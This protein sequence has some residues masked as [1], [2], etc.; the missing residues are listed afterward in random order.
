MLI[1]DHALGATSGVIL[2]SSCAIALVGGVPSC[3]LLG[4]SEGAARLLPDHIHHTVLEGLLVLREPVLLP[5]VIKDARVHV[6]PLHATLEK[7]NASPVVRLLLE[8][9]SAAILHELT[10]LGRV[11][12]AKLLERRL[13]LLLLDIVV[14]FIL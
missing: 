11:P 4:G 5:G 13:N 12:A 14:L 7:A 9:E 8:L 3:I 10:E 2:L 1:N 6:M